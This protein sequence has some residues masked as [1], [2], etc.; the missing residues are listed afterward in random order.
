MTE[1]QSSLRDEYGAKMETLPRTVTLLNPILRGFYPDPSICRVDDNYYVVTSTFEYFPAVPIF[2]SKDLVHW[3]QIGHVLTRPE[4]VPLTGIKS[5][6]GIFAPTLRHHNGVFYMITTNVEAGGSFYVTAKDPAGPWSEPIWLKEKEWSMDPSL[7]FDDDGK[8]YYTRHGE[9]RNGAIFQHEIDLETGELSPEVPKKIWSG[10]G[11]VWPEGPHLYKREGTYYL[12]I[13]EGGTS[14]DHMVTIARS[15]SPWG[16]FETHPKNP[17]FTHRHLPQHPIQATGHSDFVVTQEG[18]WFMSFLGFRPAVGRFHHLGRET[19]LAPVT[20][21][22]GWPVIN[23]RK[24]VELTMSVPGLPDSHPWPSDP[25]KIDFDR[26]LGFEWNYLRNPDMSAYSLNERVGFL[27]LKGGSAS[28]D[29][30]ASPTFVG[31]RQRAYNTR[32]SVELEFSPEKKGQEAGLVVR[33]SEDNH[34]DLVVQKDGKNRVVI[35]RTKILGNEEQPKTAVEKRVMVAAGPLELSIQS[36]RQEWE[37]FVK[38]RDKERVSLGKAPTQP[39]ASEHRIE[40]TG[41]YYGLYATMGSRGSMPPADFDS[42][43]YLE[44]GD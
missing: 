25:S 40:F 12:M 15:K 37:F 21:E 35:L 26:P 2:H 6:K 32:V 8:V 34:Y 42:F 20:W 41:A 28:L 38:E 29:D 16:P 30:R 13:S 1:T 33:S 18:E 10:T 27:R 22:D 3:R 11:D 17:I 44:F 4:Q 23:G 36:S 31:R 39:F 24:P 7:F 9:G 5:S 43:E 19:Y 14:Y